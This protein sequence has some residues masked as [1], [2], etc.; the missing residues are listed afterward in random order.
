MIT[1]FNKIIDEDGFFQWWKPQIQ[2][3]D[4]LNQDHKA[5][6]EAK[7]GSYRVDSEYGN[8]LP[9]TLTQGIPARE[10]NMRIVTETREMTLQDGRFKECIVDLESI[11]II[12]DNLD[13][14]YKNVKQDGTTIDR[15]FA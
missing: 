13:F 2:G 5:R 10:L 15:E 6:S 8:P 11:D 9:N 12:N 14:K 7:Q 4:L 1:G 3:D